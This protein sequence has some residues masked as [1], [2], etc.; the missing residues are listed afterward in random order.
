MIVD[1]ND[2][3]KV[4]RQTALTAIFEAVVIGSLAGDA[5]I[6][7]KMEANWR[8][9][10]T[11]PANEARRQVSVQAIIDKHAEKLWQKK[12]SLRK[13]QT[14]TAREIFALVRADIDDT[15]K[16]TNEKGECSWP[17]GWKPAGEKKEIGRIRKRVHNVS[18]RE[19][20]GIGEV[21]APDN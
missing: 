12:P 1:S 10:A 3:V 5:E 14:G 11:S 9:D 8:K 20:I 18:N 4:D 15:L 13:N 21:T 6:I 16:T 2:S 7:K 19:P 17:T